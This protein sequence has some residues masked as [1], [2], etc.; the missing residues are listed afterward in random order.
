MEQ[1]VRSMAGTP[2]VAA[3]LQQAQSD[4]ASCAAELEEHRAVSAG[5]QREM[6]EVRGAAERKEVERI[7]AERR[8]ARAGVNGV[9]GGPSARTSLLSHQSN[10]IRRIL[11]NSMQSLYLNYHPLCNDSQDKPPLCTT[12]NH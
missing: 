7:L 6:G 5:L 8:D 9:K 10:S 3:Q 11:C 2:S 4:L 1:H 12:C